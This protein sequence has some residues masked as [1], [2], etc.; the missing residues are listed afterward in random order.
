MR[1]LRNLLQARSIAVSEPFG[2]PTGSLTLLALISA[3]PHSSQAELAAQAGITGPNVVGIIDELERR[4]LVTRERS[5]V[6]R[7]RNMVL[8]SEKGERTMH[9]LFAEVSKIEAPIREELG[10]ED[11]AKFIDYIERTL[12]ALTEGEG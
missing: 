3:N 4:D 1:L 9:T 5:S 12:V 2:L 7:R 10:D 11:L 8:L 6:D